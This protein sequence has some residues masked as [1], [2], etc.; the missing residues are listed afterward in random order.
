[1]NRNIAIKAFLFSVLITLISA[2]AIKQLENFKTLADKKQY[3]EIVQQQVDCT[4]KVEGCDQLWLIHGMACYHQAKH[5][6]DVKQNYQC[7][8]GDLLRG[9]EFSINSG[10]SN[11]TL[12]PYAQALLESIRERQDLSTNWNESAPYT[13]LLSSQAK[14]FREVYP[15]DPDGYYYGATAA[16][17][18]ANKLIIQNIAPNT[19]CKLLDEAK[20]LINKGAKNPGLYAANFEQT[21]RQVNISAQKECRS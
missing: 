21:G 12:K 7:A 13:E 18:Q 5:N 19:A 15:T 3:N 2:C 14:L 4:E 10:Q 17:L 11:A 6:I 8:I 16:L 9:L 1:M 20:S